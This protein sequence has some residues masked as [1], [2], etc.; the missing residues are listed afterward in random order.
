MRDPRISFRSRGL[1]AVLALLI[2]GAGH[3]YQ[4]RR[5]KAG[6]FAVCILS[7]FF[8]GMVLGEWQPVYSQVVHGQDAH[9][10][11][12]AA[13]LSPEPLKT[14]QSMGYYAQ[15][16]VG[17]PAMPALIQAWRCGRDNEPME[18]PESPMEAR[19]RG[20]LLDDRG[21]EQTFVTGRI[22]M[23]PGR[24]KTVSGE[25]TGKSR[26]GQPLRTEISGRTE[27]GRPV[28]G[29]PLCE[30]RC[31]LASDD[32]RHPRHL[33]GTIDRPFYNWFQAP[34]DNNELDRLNNTLSQRY[35]VACVFTWIAGLLNLMVI[36][37]AFD[38]PAYG[39]GDE[40][41]DDESEDD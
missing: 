3:F 29:S 32:K 24:G 8:A 25:F 5:V 37:D 21:A 16:F 6:I 20:V 40:K 30:I 13:Q 39:Y 38:G 31:E 18:V 14:K 35:D 15:V 34:R 7:T 17:L 2:P 19:F 23:S 12:E 27:I 4:D 10:S 41:P 26:D 1:A 28:F 36:W 11:P 9:R 22:Q 33:A